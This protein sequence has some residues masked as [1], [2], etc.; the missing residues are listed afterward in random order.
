[1]FCY[2]YGDY[3][4]LYIPKKV[5]GLLNGNN[6]LDSPMKLFAAAF[7]LTIPAFMIF[8]SLILRPKISR[9]LNIILG[10]FFTLLMLIIAVLSLTKWQ[11][12]YVFLAVVESVITSLVIWQAWTWKKKSSI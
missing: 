7:M 9:L 12:F 3:F 2:I 1:M 6:L 10:A 8:L 11:T 4:E 5:E